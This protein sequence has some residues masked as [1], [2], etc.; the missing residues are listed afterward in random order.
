MPE[1]RTINSQR[2]ESP[3]K[4]APE[5]HRLLSE[6][7]SLAE[8]R[9]RLMDYLEESTRS[10][11]DGNETL[12]DWNFLIRRDAL[13]VFLSMI[14]ERNEKASENSMLK[15][16]WTAAQ[17]GDS[18][19]SP[20]FI[21]E[22]ESLFMALTQRTDVY[23]GDLI[24][25]L[26]EV[27]FESMHGREA[28][29]RRSDFLDG[30]GDRMDEIISHYPHGLTPEVLARREEN[31]KRVLEAFDGVESDW[32]DYRWHYRNV[33]RDSQGLEKMLR[34]IDMEPGQIEAIGT[35]IQNDIPFGVTPHYLHLMDRTRS[36]RDMAVR[37][38]VFPPASYV[39][40]VLSHMNDRNLAFDF[41]R[42]HDTSP[43]AHI[44]RRYVKVAILKPYDTCPQ[45][46]VYCQRNWEI[47]SPFAD[48]AQVSQKD[49]D[50]AVEWI[51]THPHIIDLLITGGDPLVMSNAK[52]ESL[53][54]RL[55]A[56][57][58]LKTIRIATRF[59]VTLPE[60]IDDE[61]VDMLARYHDPGRRIIYMVTHIQHPY[62]I[63]Q[64]TLDA[65]NRVRNRGMG[66]YN[67]QVFTFSN[68]R[69]YESVALRMALRMIGV[70]PY[71]VFNMKGKSE[72]EDYAVPIARILQE[73][74]EEA[75]MLPGIF[76]TDEPVFNVPFLG[77]NHVRANQ[78]HELI[79]IMPDGRRV[80]AF[81][82]WERNIRG[83]RSYIYRD[84]PIES[85]LQ[86][87]EEVGE[88]RRDYRTIWYYY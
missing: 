52:L 70:D 69:R 67:Q 8:A 78:D 42:E 2:W 55:A 37:M 74:K 46:C 79:S 3:W 29:Q 75:R 77:K 40:A 81:H 28:A 47:T 68:S 26:E 82:A 41:M 63:C 59:P 21:K 43:E 31:R 1:K 25:G 45:I 33:I 22:I 64:E 61:L 17:T 53:L 24:R 38:Q 12:K 50:K 56:I 84:V 49:L 23:P 30:M 87:L 85:Y 80:Y 16:I 44:T 11:T 35:A 39:N 88:S 62:E 19:V 65:V 66:V 6:A 32:S 10:L 51:E 86:K 48:G 20:E 76:R 5:I 71:Y 4:I 60:R 36:V 13:R 14:S 18:E 83:V 72:M 54:D 15:L 57:P 34:V 58:H 9:S 73:R 27:D 7:P